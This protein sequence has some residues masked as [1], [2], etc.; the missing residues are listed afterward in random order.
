MK[1]ILGFGL[2][3][4]L[5]NN[6]PGA[7][8]PIGEISPV[9]A[10]SSRDIG[11]YTD[12]NSTGTSFLSFYA[13]DEK[14]VAF[15]LNDKF[16]QSILKLQAW[17]LPR[18]TDGRFT[19]DKA[20]VHQQIK[21]DFGGTWDDLIIGDMVSDGKNWS[22]EWV[23]GKLK[24]DDD[25][26]IKIWFADESF[27]LGYPKFEL[28][29]VHPL[30]LKGMDILHEDY[31]TAKAAV[32]GVTKGD[33]TRWINDAIGSHP[34]TFIREL[35]F[36]VY[37]KFNPKKYQVCYWQVIGWGF[38]GNNDDAIYELLK[39]EIL[40]NS[41][42]DED[43]WVKVIPD[44]FNPR[45][46]TIMPDWLSYSIPEKQVRESLN[47]PIVDYETMLVRPLKA[48]K[49]WDKAHIIKSLQVVP[50]LHKSLACYF[51]GKPTNLDGQFK[52]RE[53]YPDYIL[54]PSDRAE[55]NRMSKRT[56]EFVYG[57][58]ELLLA[59][60]NMT[61]FTPIPAGVSRVIRDGVICATKTMDGVKFVVITKPYMEELFK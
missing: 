49:W 47:S 24:G 40:K 15:Q 31:A 42:Y 44:L 56:A 35:D 53:L 48:F 26:L 41:K 58:Q 39:D 17:M 16:K 20:I 7:V 10:T 33:V 59:A 50:F 22:P 55:A 38:N 11:I 54:V 3:P 61:E 2:Y 27:K 46:F 18:I 57:M 12:K 29:A 60:E 8:N 6:L 23:Q 28:A 36:K 34:Q 37:D 4:S 30:E 51:V 43:E 52:I 13:A 9:A 5:S 1:Y 32:D 19:N 25:N 21:A 45:E 14:N